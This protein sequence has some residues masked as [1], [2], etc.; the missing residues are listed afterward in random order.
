MKKSC[1][2]KVRELLERYNIKLADVKEIIIVVE[3]DKNIIS[4]VTNHE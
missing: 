1:V 4:I 3:D 2:V